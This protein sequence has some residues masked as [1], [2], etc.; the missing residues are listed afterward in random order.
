MEIKQTNK[1]KNKTKKQPKPTFSHVRIITGPTLQSVLEA[2]VTLTMISS[3][4][5][6][7]QVNIH[8]V[9]PSGI[10]LSICTGACW[11]CALPFSVVIISLRSAHPT[12]DGTE[13]FIC[14]PLHSQQAGPNIK[15]TFNTNGITNTPLRQLL[16]LKSTFEPKTGDVFFFFF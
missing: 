5:D 6:V 3:A 16:G 14:C 15:M 4:V 11:M 1:K 13:S 8:Q 7:K 2:T 9:S 10:Y 12:C